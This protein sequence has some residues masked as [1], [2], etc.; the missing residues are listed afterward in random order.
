MVYVKCKIHEED[1]E[2]YLIKNLEL[3]YILSNDLESD[4]FGLKIEAIHVHKTEAVGSKS[5]DSLNRLMAY[6]AIRKR[7]I[8][9]HM[10]TDRC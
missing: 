5:Y 4:T 3:V 7:P 10:V 9:K 8:L 6:S 2:P 1:H